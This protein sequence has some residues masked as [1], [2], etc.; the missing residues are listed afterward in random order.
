MRPKPNSDYSSPHLATFV[1]LIIF[2]FKLQE[3]ILLN[4]L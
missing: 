4:V 3:V 2:T 1:V